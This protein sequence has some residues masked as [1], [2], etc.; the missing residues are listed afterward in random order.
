M[1]V[2]SHGNLINV[3]ENVPKLDYDLELVEGTIPVGE[4]E[5]RVERD[6]GTR[7]ERDEAGGAKRYDWDARV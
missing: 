3:D 4:L 1:A 2:D 7:C 6:E 5:A